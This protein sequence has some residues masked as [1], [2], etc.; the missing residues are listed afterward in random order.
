MQNTTDF[1]SLRGTARMAG[2]VYLTLFAAGIVAEFFVR[3]PLIVPGDAASTAANITAAEGLFRAG[4][5]SDLIMII[6]DIALAYLFY[7]LL[8]PVSKPLAIIA[9]LFRLAQAATLGMNLLNLFFALELLGGGAYLSAL[10]AR[11]LQSLALLFVNAHGTGYALGLVFFGVSLAV[12]GYLTVKSGYL[13][14]LLGVLL[15]VASAGYLADSF[16]RT[17]L[18]SYEQYAP[19]FD[20]AVFMPAFIAELAMTLW[21]LIRG[22][23]VPATARIEGQAGAPALR[24]AP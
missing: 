22:V 12:V 16:A 18:V 8:K 15:I 5:A 19:V 1:K 2:A 10:D 17:L 6:C 9:A 11:E 7:E 3:S 21:L 20:T 23:R 14:A 13:P 24:S 4:I